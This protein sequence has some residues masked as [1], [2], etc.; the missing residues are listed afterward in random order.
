MTT[1]DVADLALAD[2]GRRKIRWAARHMPVLATNREELAAAV[3]DLSFGGLALS[4]RYLLQHADELAPAMHDVPAEIDEQ[5]AA[6]K[7]RSLGVRLDVLDARQQQY[8][9]SWQHGT[10][11]AS[12]A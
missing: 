2:Q 4:A 8:A 11:D 6:L 7:L 5:V 3:M 1:F 10:L 12:V 9:R